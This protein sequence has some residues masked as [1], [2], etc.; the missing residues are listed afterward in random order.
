M[1]REEQSERPRPGRLLALVGSDTADRS[2]LARHLLDRGNAV[3][4][5]PGPPGCPLLREEPCGMVDTADAVILLPEAERDR[6]IVRALSM[7]AQRACHSL[8]IEPS[9]V[10]PDTGS[11]RVRSVD[12]AAI[13]VS[14][15]H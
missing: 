5:C 12:A 6:E 2:R 7:C 15:F 10:L 3:V 11:V 8:V 1:A 13:A 9:A 4:I 14:A